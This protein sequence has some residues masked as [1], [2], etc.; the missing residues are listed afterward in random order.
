MDNDAQ[1]LL[2]FDLRDVARFE[3]F[4]IENNQTLI[5]DLQDKTQL[6]IFFYGPSGSGKTHLL[7]SLCHEYSSSLKSATYIPLARYEELSPQIF[8]G[9]E[10]MSLVCIDDIQVIAGMTEWETELFHL[11]N[12]LRDKKGKIVVSSALSLKSLAINLADLRSRFSWGPVYQIKSLTDANKCLALQQHAT[13]R[14]LELSD[15]VC[16]YLL[17][18]YTRDVSS[19][20]D[21]L[22]ILDKAALVAKRKLTIPFVRTIL[23]ND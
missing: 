15:E 2:N 14:G 1:L 6:C 13:A 19:L 11:Y 4:I 22:E 3:N 21:M 16:E 7:H 5:N 18:R 9:L 8:N 23:A 17:S 20:F 12:R 10:N